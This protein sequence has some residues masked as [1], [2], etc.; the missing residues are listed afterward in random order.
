MDLTY[1]EETIDGI[2]V[3]MGLDSPF[4]RFVFFGSITSAILNTFKP[5]SLYY[6]N[7]KARAS[8]LVPSVPDDGNTV[9]I[10]W[11]G[12]SLIIATTSAIY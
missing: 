10:P 12:Y 4:S 6:E 5:K 11:W 7:G 2:L 8:Y 1:L 9:M 3:Y